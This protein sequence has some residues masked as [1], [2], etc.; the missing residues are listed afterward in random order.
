MPNTRPF[1]TEGKPV[2]A[3]PA[4]ESGPHQARPD[5]I[6]ACPVAQAESG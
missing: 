6:R 2:R 1:H 5:R 3:H 4:L